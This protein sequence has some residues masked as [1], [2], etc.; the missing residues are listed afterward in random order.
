MGHAT[1]LTSPVERAGRVEEIVETGLFY[2]PDDPLVLRVIRRPHRIT[3]GDDGGAVRRAGRP[4]GWRESGERLSRELDVNLGRSGAVSLPVV[5][6]GPSEAVV[7]RRIAAASL[8]LYQT[9]L[10]L[11]SQH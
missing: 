6:A 1:V 7:V 5:D 8:A 11:D 2:G 3:V 9:L 10:E 4:P